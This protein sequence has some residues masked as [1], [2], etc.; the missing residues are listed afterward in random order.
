MPHY[1]GKKGRFGKDHTCMTELYNQTRFA[2][3]FD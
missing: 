1:M 2:V 3:T